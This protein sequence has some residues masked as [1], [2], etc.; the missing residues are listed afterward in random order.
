MMKILLLTFIPL[1]RRPEGGKPHLGS[2]GVAERRTSS[3]AQIGSTRRSSTTGH[4]GALEHPVGDRC[5][6][7]SVQVKPILGAAVA[8]SR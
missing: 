6:S 1:L 8:S 3:S 7:A 5:S 2:G 4:S